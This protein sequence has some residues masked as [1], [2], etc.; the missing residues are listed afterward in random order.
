MLEKFTLLTVENLKF[1]QQHHKVYASIDYFTYIISGTWVLF[2]Y[3]IS[4]IW[5]L[6]LVYNI[7]DSGPTFGIQYRG[8][9]SYKVCS[10]ENPWLGP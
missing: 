1:S 8:L 4:G 9:G 5:V 2:W 6:V 7:G 10:N 3:A